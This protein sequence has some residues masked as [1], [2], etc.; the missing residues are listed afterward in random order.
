MVYASDEVCAKRIM[1]RDLVTKDAALLSIAAQM[2]I[3]EKVGLADFVVDNTA[4]FA[5]TVD[6]L[7]DLVETG[8]FSRKTKL[9]MNNT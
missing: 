6:Q 2:P 5:E 1:Q 9:A 8:C 7:R 3:E 4:S